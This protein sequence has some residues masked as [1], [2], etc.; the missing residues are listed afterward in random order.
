MTAAQVCAL[1][2]SQITVRQLPAAERARVLDTV[3]SLVG[4][5]GTVRPFLTVAYTARKP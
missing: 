2:A 5:V 1:Y 4:P 3:M